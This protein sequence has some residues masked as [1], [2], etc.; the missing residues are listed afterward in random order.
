[1]KDFDELLDEV[2]QEDATTQPR[3]GLEGRVMARV[4]ADEGL[5]HASLSQAWDR[6]RKWLPV[7]AAACLGVAALVWYGTGGGTSRP[8]RVDSRASAPALAVPAVETSK[9]TAAI[10]RNSAPQVGARYLLAEGVARRQPKRVR[11][12]SEDEPKLETFPAVSQKGNAS[13]WLGG[14]DNGK[15]AAIASEVTPAV[16][17]AYRQLQEAQREPIDIA[18]IE[19]TPLQ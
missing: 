19:I 11:T 16:A 8:A 13:G 4:Q 12:V 18:A 15:L 17:K 5:L 10:A 6:W 3:T 14:D 9:S 7:P 1:M 2:L